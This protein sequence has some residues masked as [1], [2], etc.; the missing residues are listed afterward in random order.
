MEWLC[1]S[2]V[3]LLLLPNLH[4]C[5]H[6]LVQD[7]G[8]SSLVT[9]IITARHP[10]SAAR[11][12]M[13]RAASSSRLEQARVDS[14]GSILDT[15]WVNI[16][17]VRPTLSGSAQR[18]S[19][20]FRVIIRQLMSLYRW[21]GRDKL[22]LFINIWCGAPPCRED[23]KKNIFYREFLIGGNIWYFT[24]HKLHYLKTINSGD[25]IKTT[26]AVWSAWA[27]SLGHWEHWAEAIW[28]VPTLNS[29]KH[30]TS[31]LSGVE[32]ALVTANH[33]TSLLSDNKLCTPAWLTARNMG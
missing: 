4:L 12:D 30:N 31:H 28:G 21:L 18:I 2:C 17:I 1:Q 14:Q 29:S 9:V 6:G 23:I 10:S 26:L 7:P 8:V 19:R 20:N 5:V 24:R 16:N 33:I 13:T 3:K 15:G 27:A 11:I 32:R 25:S 22:W